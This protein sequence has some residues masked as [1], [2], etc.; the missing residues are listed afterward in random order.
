MTVRERA[1]DDRD[2]HPMLHQAGLALVNVWAQREVEGRPARKVYLA[3]RGP[4]VSLRR[5]AGRR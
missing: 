3:L 5:A 4:A 1:W 2:L